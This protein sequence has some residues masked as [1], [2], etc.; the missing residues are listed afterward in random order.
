MPTP[1]A[2]LNAAGNAGNVDQNTANVTPDNQ[3]Q[4]GTQNI[5]S[6]QNQQN[7]PMPIEELLKKMEET[8]NARMELMEKKYQEQLAI[9]NRQLEEE[10]L[11]QMSEKE[12][13]EHNRRLEA[14]KQLEKEQALVEQIKALEFEKTRAMNAEYIGKIVAEKPYLKTIIEKMK[15]TNAEE[16]DKYVKPNEDIYKQHAEMA[17]YMSTNTSRDVFSIYGENSNNNLFSSEGTDKENI[18]KTRASSILDELLN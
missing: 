15:I 8:N 16:Y 5:D 11:K 4:S 6:T 2:D 7:A 9:M 14:Q 10:K 13:E 17:K 12:R 1:N 18:I 3:N